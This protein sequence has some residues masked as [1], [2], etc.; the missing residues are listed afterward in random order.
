MK[1]H[2]RSKKI[3]ALA[4]VLILCGSLFTGCLGFGEKAPDKEDKEQK[5][6]TEDTGSLKNKKEKK[7]K[8]KKQ[9]DASDR[10]SLATKEE[11]LSFLA[12]E[13]TMLDRDTDEAFALLTIEKDGRF[14]F[15]RNEDGASGNGTLTFEHTGQEE[16]DL[17]DSFRLGFRNMEDLLPAGVETYGESD[18]ETGGMFHIGQSPGKDY[19]YLRELGNGES[20]IS[21]YV[22]NTDYDWNSLGDSPM[23]WLF[24]RDHENGP[25]ASPVCGDSFYAWAWDCDD[26]GTLLL[27][28]MDPATF[29]TEEEYSSRRFMGGHFFELEEIGA[30][31]YPTDDDTDTS[32]LVDADT[33]WK[34]HP[35]AMYEVE[36]NDD[37]S[38]RSI[39]EV[40]ESFYGIYDLGWVEPEVSYHDMMLSVD[41]TTIDMTEYAPSATAIMDTQRVGDWLIVDCH[42]NP[43]VGLYEFYNLYSGYMGM[44]EYEIAGSLLTWQ[45]DDL[46]TGVYAYYNEVHDIWGNLIGE[47]RDGE[48]FDLKITKNNTVEAECWK[49]DEAGNEVSFTEE[50]EYE[51]HDRAAW[52]YFEYLLGGNRQWRRLKEDA[53]DALAL[54]LVNPPLSIL[55]WTPYVDVEDGTTDVVAAVSLKDGQVFHLESASPDASGTD[56]NYGDFEDAQRGRA[57][58]Y[59]LSIPEGSVNDRLIIRTPGY[60]EETWEVGHLSGRVP[61]ISRYLP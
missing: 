59:R 46:S 4:T 27:Q 41:G 14:D 10:V 35:L 54:V 6:K 58:V 60:P 21:C 42:V 26:A 18:Y 1:M 33:L 15:V 29:E 45:G 9:A 3:L 61:L 39:R 24:V 2:L 51:P 57:I 31:Y 19:L 44:F 55:N 53:G 12:G 50:F 28:P 47:I 7:K 43:H 25:E 8:E 36:T 56:A 52:L 34:N 30:A 17:P 20:M 37:G 48:I 11:I 40:D 5:S 16:G 22:F 13:W 49:I 38:I 23:E 32:E